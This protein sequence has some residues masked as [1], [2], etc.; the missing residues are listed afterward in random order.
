MLTVQSGSSCISVIR[1]EVTGESGNK[2][3]DSD[4]VPGFTGLDGGSSVSGCEVVV[5]GIKK[6][7]PKSKYRMKYPQLLVIFDE[8]SMV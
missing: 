4:L 3:M 6:R 1:F 7:R 5:L 2:M 8:A